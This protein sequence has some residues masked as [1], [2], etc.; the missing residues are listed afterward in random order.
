MMVFRDEAFGRKL[1]LDKIIQTLKL[2]YMEI[3][4]LQKL[5]QLVISR[6]SGI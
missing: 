5:K 3:D 4:K 1:G 2:N 6:I